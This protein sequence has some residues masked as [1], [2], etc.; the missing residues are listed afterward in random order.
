MNV[1]FLLIFVLIRFAHPLC[2][3]TS[4]CIERIRRL[5]AEPRRFWF[6]E[7][8]KLVSYGFRNFRIFPFHSLGGRLFRVKTYQAAFLQ[9][10]RLYPRVT[11]RTQPGTYRACDHDFVVDKPG[12]SIIEVDPDMEP[13]EPFNIRYLPD[14]RWPGISRNDTFIILITDA[15][16]GTLNFVAYDYP[17]NSKVLQHYKPSENFRPLVNPLVVIVFQQAPKRDYGNLKIT[18]GSELF[19]LPKFMIDNALESEHKNTILS[20]L[21][22]MNIVMV[23]ADAYSIEKQRIR[24]IV[25]NCHSL[26]Q[27]KLRKDN[28]WSFVNAFPLSEM[29]TSLSVDYQQPA[30][31]YEVCCEQIDLWDM[32]LPLD[33]LGDGNLPSLVVHNEPRVSAIR[34]PQNNANYQRSAR[35]F[36]GVVL[37]DY[38]YSLV[39]FD[40]D[41]AFLH[42]LI[43]DIPS[44]SLAA[45]SINDGKT[46]GCVLSLSLR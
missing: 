36:V 32:W 24:A 22:G 6:G 17:K 3:E 9:N 43:I 39:L 10:L 37:F 20:D 21:V 41:R 8:W 14:I 1:S 5:V 35:D 33:P 19:N 27:Q 26:I 18:D 31:S 44:A 42:W 29:D 34:I 38:S 30:V 12:R 40:P 15:G 11:F 4:L 16:F 28:R 2:S 13:V 7:Q 46:V 45:S 23:S 25:D